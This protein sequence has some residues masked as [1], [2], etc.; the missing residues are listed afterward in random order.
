MHTPEK[1]RKKKVFFSQQRHGGWR[2]VG[3]DSQHKKCKLL[4]D[5]QEGV[6]INEDCVGL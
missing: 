4:T 3:I 6:E 1:K 5:Q 2:V